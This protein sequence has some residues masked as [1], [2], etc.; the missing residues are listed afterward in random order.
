MKILVK[1]INFIFTA[2]LIYMAYLETGIYT[3]C[4]LSLIYVATLLQS[5][6]ND[7]QG[8]INKEILRGFKLIAGKG[9]KSC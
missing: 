1:V 6:L 4:V 8:E 9:D 3:A 2:W 5:V 7:G